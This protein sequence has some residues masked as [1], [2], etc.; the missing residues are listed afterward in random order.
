MLQDA[1]SL[2]ICCIVILYQLIDCLTLS[3][4]CERVTVVCFVIH[5]F[6][7]SLSKMADFYALKEEEL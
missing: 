5:S 1:R 7:L 6:I 2:C 3:A 4:L